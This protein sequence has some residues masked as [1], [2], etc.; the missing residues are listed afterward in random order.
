MG[1]RVITLLSAR[2]LTQHL[3]VELE[4]YWPVDFDE[5][6]CSVEDLFEDLSSLPQSVDPAS[7]GLHLEDSQ[8]KSMGLI[9]SQLAREGTVYLSTWYYEL[10]PTSMTQNAFNE[11]MHEEAA[12]LRPVAKVVEMVQKLPTQ[13]LGFHIRR[14]DHWRNLRYSPL[15]LFTQIMDQYGKKNVKTTFVLATDSKAVG[16]LLRRRYGYQLLLLEHDQ[17]RDSIEGVQTA[18]ADVLTLAQTEKLYGCSTSCFAHLVQLLSQRPRILLSLSS[19]L[20]ESLAAFD[21]NPYD[22]RHHFLIRWNQQR[23][24]WLPSPQLSWF[25]FGFEGFRYWL[26]TKFILSDLYQLWPFHRGHQFV[27][28]ST[29]RK[30]SGL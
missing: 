5:C 10:R 21:A 18:L 3:G 20:A 7:A 19:A 6:A 9:E 15:S 30:K 4:F 23:H 14:E 17:Y 1:S 29:S 11:S 24:A 28:V 8:G 26:W 27:R 25:Q 22:I 12:K 16:Q 2:V 13:T